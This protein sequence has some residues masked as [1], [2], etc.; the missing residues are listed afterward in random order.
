MRKKNSWAAFSF[1]SDTRARLPIDRNRKKYHIRKGSEG[2]NMM[3]HIELSSNRPPVPA[4]LANKLGKRNK[5][6]LAIGTNAKNDE[7]RRM[8]SDQETRRIA[9]L[10]KEEKPKP[11]QNVIQRLFGKQEKQ[12]SAETST[13]DSVETTSSTE[14]KPTIGDRIAVVGS[15]EEI[16]SSASIGFFETVLTAYNHHCNLRT[17]PDDWWFCVIKKVAMAI[18]DNAEKESVRKLFVNHAGKKELVVVVEEWPLSQV[19]D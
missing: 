17:S 11:K 19:S 14:N 1:E 8:R 16:Y 5:S 2:A 4:D 13:E 18:N 3:K 9:E 7:I 6:L 12:G 10:E 15:N